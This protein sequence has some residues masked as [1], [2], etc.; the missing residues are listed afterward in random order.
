MPRPLFPYFAEKNT[1]DLRLTRPV[2]R[3][4]F[5]C[6]APLPPTM[7]ALIHAGYDARGPRLTGSPAPKIR[8]GMHATNDSRDLRFS[9]CRPP[10]YYGS[11]DTRVLRLAGPPPLICD[12]KI[13]ASYDARG[14]R[15]RG[16]H[17]P[18]R[19]LDMGELRCAGSMM[20]GSND[21]LGAFPFMRGRGRARLCN[22]GKPW[23]PRPPPFDMVA[24]IQGGHDGR[25]LRYPRSVNASELPCPLI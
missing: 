23:F 5:D 25:E 15:F 3:A 19:G 13:Q 24:M 1:R 11:N 22:G 18:V 2:I 10:P 9:G 6:R 8:A 21:F 16:S 12:K 20:R 17:T 14:L 4:I 7:H